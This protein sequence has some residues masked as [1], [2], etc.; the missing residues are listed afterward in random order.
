MTNEACLFWIVIDLRV[1]CTAAA[2]GANCTAALRQS[3]NEGNWKSF[4]TCCSED[5]RLWT[6]GLWKLDS[7]RL[8]ATTPSPQP[9]SDLK[10]QVDMIFVSR[11][12]AKAS[13]STRSLENIKPKSEP[14]PVIGQAWPR[15]LRQ[16]GTWPLKP[17]KGSCKRD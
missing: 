9:C 7:S 5:R 12:R 6:I 17:G 13:S 11:Y 2:A 8:S 1:L 15:V 10:I 14:T 3:T 4:Q 16:K